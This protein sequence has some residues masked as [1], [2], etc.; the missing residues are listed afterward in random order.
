LLFLVLSTVFIRGK[1]R[2]FSS[3]DNG[4]NSGGQ[5]DRNQ[6][7]DHEPCFKAQT[8][9][10]RFSQILTS[11]RVTKCTDLHPSETH[12][13]HNSCS[14]MGRAMWRFS[15]HGITYFSG[16]KPAKIPKNYIFGGC[17]SIRQERGRRVAIDTPSTTASSS[18]ADNQGREDESGREGWSPSSLSSGVVSSTSGATTLMLKVLER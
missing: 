15:Q 14:T 7:A 18:I 9:F 13:T 11:N 4:D 10:F 12:S 17:A 5:N 8:A 1:D 2:G 3:G 16:E 6:Q